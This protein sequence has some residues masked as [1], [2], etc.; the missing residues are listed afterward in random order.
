MPGSTVTTIPGLRMVW[1]LTASRGPSWTN[2]PSPCPSPWRKRRPKPA[3]AMTARATLSTSWADNARPNGGDR[4]RLG[5]QHNPIYPLEFGRDFTCN[6]H[7][8]QVAA[9]QPLVGAPIDQHEVVLADPLCGRAWH[10]ATPPAARRPQ[11]WETPRPWRRTA[12][13]GA[14]TRRPPLSRSFPAATWT[15]ARANAFSA[16]Q[17]ALRSRAISSLSLISRSF[18]TRPEVVT[19]SSFGSFSAIWSRSPT[20]IESPSMPSRPIFAARTTRTTAWSI[21]TPGG[22][23]LRST[24]GTLFAQ[25]GGISRV[26]QHRLAVA[27]DQQIAVVAGK[28]GQI[29]DIG[30]IGD[31]QGVDAAL[32][33]RLAK[34]I[35]SGLKVHDSIS[36]GRDQGSGVR[37]R[38]SG[39]KG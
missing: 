36:R 31:Q 39:I 22:R 19:S 8:R 18:S 27:A 29:G 11:C 38:G 13:T 25:L 5:L 12:G 3:L 10:G 35:A 1:F 20:V 26:A 32:A 23:M 21:V 16:C 30:E 28:A 2:M 33:E 9:V 37:D 17:T 7:S 15:A 4:P 14:P 24:P 6:Q 34:S